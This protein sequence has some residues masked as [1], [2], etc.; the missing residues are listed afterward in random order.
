MSTPLCALADVQA[1]TGDSTTGT[2]SVYTA[3]IPKVSAAIEA[4]CSRTFG[5]ASYTENR[6]GNGADRIMVRN[7]PLTAVTSVMVDTV[8]I[9]AA[10]DAVSFGYVFDD[11]TIYIRAG[12]KLSP[13]PAGYLGAYP[14]C[15]SRGVQNIALAYTGGY[16]T[17]PPDVN[18]AACEWI[19][20]KT[21]KRSRLDKKSEVL[22]QQTV[23]FDLSGM[24]DTVKAL[25]FT[26]RTVLVPA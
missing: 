6:N 4:Y 9:P 20:F 22:A 26:Y 10:P 15:F 2:A 19:S 17:I 3:L 5:Q 21:A 8:P 16:A 23:S 1:Y 13:P 11:S 25:L 7:L 14:V 24:P 18:Q 12:R